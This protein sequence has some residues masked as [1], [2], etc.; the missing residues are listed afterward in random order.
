MQFSWTP[1]CVLPDLPSD[2]LQRELHST[3]IAHKHS[4]KYEKKVEFVSDAYEIVDR[5]VILG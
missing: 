1:V 5:I 4:Q 2:D 3:P